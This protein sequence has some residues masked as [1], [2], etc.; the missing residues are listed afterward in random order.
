M[1]GVPVGDIGDEDFKVPAILLE[2]GYFVFREIGDEV[3]P[4][5]IVAVVCFQA[6]SGELVDMGFICEEDLDAGEGGWCLGGEGEGGG[7]EEDYAE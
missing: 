4:G 1:G 2:E 3:F 5:G 6:E 7:K